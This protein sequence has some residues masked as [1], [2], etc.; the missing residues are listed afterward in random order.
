MKNKRIRAVSFNNRR[1]EIEVTYA[2]GK[3]L[4]VHYGQLGIKKTVAK[5]WVDTETNCQ[6]V[7]F[8]FNDGTVDYMPYDQPLALNRDPEYLLQTQIEELTAKIK[9]ELSKRKISKRFLA[10]QLKTSDNQVHRLLNPTIL[11]KN[12]EQLCRIAEV[13]ELEVEIRLRKVA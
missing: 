6:S 10:K 7:A 4:N 13:L 8:A 2:T 9:C 5:A 1:K 12:L 11:N 3:K